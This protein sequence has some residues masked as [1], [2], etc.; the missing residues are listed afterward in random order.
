MVRNNLY[1]L[2][3]LAEKI[4]KEFFANPHILHVTVGADLAYRSEEYSHIHAPRWKLAVRKKGKLTMLKE[5]PP[6]SL[7]AALTKMALHGD[8]YDIIYRFLDR[9]YEAKELAQYQIINLTGQSC[10]IDIFRDSLKEYM[11][12]KL[13]RGGRGKSAEDFRLKLTC[14]DGA[15]RYYR[16]KRLGLAKVN[17]E[18]KSPSLP[19]ELRASTHS[20]EDIVLLHPLKSNQSFGSVSRSLGS[21]E[22][23][24]HLLNTLGEEKYVYHIFCNPDEF[25]RVTYRDI[26]REYGRHISQSEVDVIENGEVRYF[27]WIE[28]DIWAFSVVPVAR[29]NEQLYIG[30]QQVLPFEKESWLVNFFDGTH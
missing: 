24:L 29:K 26:D 30:E 8:I 14:L 7:N 9:I 25:T 20:G 3:T 11:P 21:V 23:R 19:Y 16:D 28:S 18:S 6:V 10:K 17:I 4:K 12:G 2:F 13:M 15:I 1:F 5:F 27:V 22:L